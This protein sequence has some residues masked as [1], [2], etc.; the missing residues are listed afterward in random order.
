[1]KIDEVNVTDETRTEHSRSVSVR[2]TGAAEQPNGAAIYMTCSARTSGRRNLEPGGEGMQIA[3][4]TDGPFLTFQDTRGGG[5]TREQ[6]ELFKR[7]GD[8][9]WSMWESRFVRKDRDE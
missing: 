1:M 2:I 4:H 5:L 3:P 6:W 7:A 9:A 8:E